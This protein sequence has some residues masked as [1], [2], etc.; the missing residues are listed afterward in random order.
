MLCNLGLGSSVFYFQILVQIV[1]P[2]A[3]IGTDEEETGGTNGAF[4]IVKVSMH[5]Q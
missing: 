5:G 4:D 2:T 1:I 3:D